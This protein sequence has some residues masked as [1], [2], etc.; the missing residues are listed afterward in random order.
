MAAHTCHLSMWRQER[1]GTSQPGLRETLFHK[2]KG[3]YGDRVWGDGEMD[4]Q[5]QRQSR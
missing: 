5:E 3:V 2:T 4:E 1:E